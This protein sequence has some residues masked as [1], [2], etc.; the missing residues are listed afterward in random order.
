MYS[1]TE[2]FS[3]EI[4]KE[5]EIKRGRVDKLLE[6]FENSMVNEDNRYSSASKK[7]TFSDQMLMME[8]STNK[9][10]KNDFKDD[11]KYFFH[12]MIQPS[13]VLKQMAADDRPKYLKGY[14][15]GVNKFFYDRRLNERQTTIK[16]MKLMHGFT[17]P[18]DNFP[19]SNT[20]V[21]VVS[22]EFM[23]FET[24][25]RTPYMCILETIEYRPL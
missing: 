19:E 11:V 2:A 25:E 15:D 4:A 16:G 20:I 18:F 12:L 6:A 14:F 24:R 21:R 23:I 10:I 13:I 7:K 8:H 1:L 22:D 5:N 3:Y 17:M 9:R